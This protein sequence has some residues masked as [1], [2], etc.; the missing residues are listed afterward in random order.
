MSTLIDRQW[1][2]ARPIGVGYKSKIIEIEA[3]E[4]AL[5][6]RKSL[7]ESLFTNLKGQDAQ[8][9]INNLNEV[10]HNLTKAALI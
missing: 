10:V 8:L 3:P 9:A 7:E 5:P 2:K 4:Q 1:Y 6:T